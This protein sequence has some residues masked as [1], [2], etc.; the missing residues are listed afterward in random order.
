MTDAL[1]FRSPANLVWM[2][3]LPVAVGM[4]TN[5]GWDR[6]CFMAMALVGVS[7]IVGTLVGVN[8]TSYG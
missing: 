4:A 2:L 7:L 6:R 1:A 8:F 5:V 3:G